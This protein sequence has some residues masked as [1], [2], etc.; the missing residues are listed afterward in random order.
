[1]EN[2]RSQW[3]H[4]QGLFFANLP[5][6]RELGVA[7]VDEFSTQGVEKQKEAHTRLHFSYNFISDEYHEFNHTLGLPT[8]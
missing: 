8:F 6:L 2:I 1:M 3:L 4:P 5:H 7:K